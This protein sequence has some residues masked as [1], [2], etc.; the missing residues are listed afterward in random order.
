M[1]QE[2]LHDYGSGGAAVLASKVPTCQKK[3]PERGRSRHLGLEK[4]PPAIKSREN[5]AGRIVLDSKSTH[6]LQKAANLQEVDWLRASRRPRRAV[7]WG[8]AKSGCCTSCKKRQNCKRLIGY[9][10]V[11]GHRG[12]WRGVRRSRAATPLA[13]TA[14]IA[15]G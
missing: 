15:R 8:S 1:Y 3:P 5:V 10:Q 4:G 7:A 14:K 13:K 9:A 6:L 12:P 2:F 11:G